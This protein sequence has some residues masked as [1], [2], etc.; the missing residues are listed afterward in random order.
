MGDKITLKVQERTV[1]G[2]KVKELRRDGLVPI[3]IYGPGMDPK[4]AQASYN[5]LE[6]VVRTAGKHTPVHLTI[7]EKKRIAMV[8][9]I[10]FNPSKNSIDHVAFHAVNQNKTIEAEVPVRLIGEGESEA[11]KAGLIILQNIDTL[12]VKALPLEMPDALEVD[13]R[14]LKEA[15]E[16]VLVSD[17]KLPDNVELVDHNDGREDEDDEGEEE[18]PTIFDLQIASV[19]E[20][21]ALEAANNA[22]AGSAED[23][24]EVEAENGAEVPVDEEQPTEDKQSN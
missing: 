1:Y 13:I 24:S 18:K 4:P 17:I 10:S 12:E 20:P 11:E 7:D 14:Y 2:K 8:K 22:S 19:W 9:E 23:V 6:K 5:E 21:A 16:R 3:V 15:G